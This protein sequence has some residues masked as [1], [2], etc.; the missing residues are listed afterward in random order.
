[1][2]L[3]RRYTTILAN[4]KL[5][6]DVLRLSLLFISK[7][8]HNRRPYKFCT[9]NF[10]KKSIVLYH[11]ISLFAS[12]G[13]KPSE[14]LLIDGKFRRERDKPYREIL[15][16]LIFCFPTRCYKDVI[17]VNE[18]RCEKIDYKF[19]KRGKFSDQDS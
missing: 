11:A 12:L 6:H 10:A 1:M 2:T 17:N 3:C 15:E 16:R 14:I 4:I 8:I 5:R 9:R 7:Q 19:L 13:V 18:F